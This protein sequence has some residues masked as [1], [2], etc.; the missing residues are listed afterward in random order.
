[1][2]GVIQDALK[3]VAEGGFVM[4]PL[5]F[6][7]ALLWYGLGWRM[8]TIRR[9]SQRP[10]RLLVADRVA[11][12]LK[13]ARGIVDG[14][15][16]AAVDARPQHHHDLVPVLAPFRE[17]MDGHASM[18]RS[19]VM[20]APLLGLLGTVSGMIETF[21][22]LGDGALYSRSG[23]IAGGISEALLTT[24]MGLCVAVPGIVAGRL[25]ERKQGHFTEE[26]DELAELLTGGHSPLSP[27]H[28]AGDVHAPL[29]DAGGA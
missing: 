13:R 11:G 18:V 4:P 21:A 29:P 24:Q 22:S 26:L 8:L 25:L 28:A 17:E 3:L 14:A 6:C 15:V 9:G 23:G 7:T 20:V 2:R 1:M 12:R 10:L 27:A 19:V 16:L 5:V